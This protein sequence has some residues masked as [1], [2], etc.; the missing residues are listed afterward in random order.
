MAKDLH[1]EIIQRLE[2][3]TLKELSPEDTF[4][5]E[6]T[7]ECMGNCCSDIDIFLDPWDVETMARHLD[8]SGQEFVKTYCILDMDEELGWPCIQ[9]KHVAEGPCAFR[10]VDG[11]CS[12]YPVRPRNCRTAPI[13]RAVRFHIKGN[14]KECQEKI[15]MITPVDSCLGYNSDKTWTVREWLEDSNAYKYYELSDIHLELIDYAANTLNT[16]KWLSGPAV[17]ML[18]PFLY[19][20]DILRSKLGITPDDVGHEEFYKRRMKALRLILTDMAAALGYG[21]KA[22]KIQKDDLKVMDKVKNTLLKG[23]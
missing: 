11:K 2:S 5:F 18:I 7:D 9:L 6:C 3:G 12:V 13:A 10:L 4:N 15:F 17:K 22:G 23:E 20:P 19:A 1:L 14:K 8:L 16:R 21:P